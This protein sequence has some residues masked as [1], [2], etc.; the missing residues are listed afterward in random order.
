MGV[1]FKLKITIKYFK[2]NKKIDF[3]FF[4]F[5]A[6]KNTRSIINDFY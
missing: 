2:N 5:L 4:L 1:I 3:S 6:F